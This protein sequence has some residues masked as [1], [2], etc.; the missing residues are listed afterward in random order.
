YGL[1]CGARKDAP[2]EPGPIQ[3]SLY[4]MCPARRLN[5]DPGKSDRSC[6]ERGAG[7]FATFYSNPSESDRSCLERGA[8]KDAA[9][10]PSPVQQ[11]LQRVRE[12]YGLD[13]DPGDSDRDRLNRGTG[14][15]AARYGNPGEGCRGCLER[16]ACDIAT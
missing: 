4:R 11:S 8:G 15:I 2:F 13:A 16:C 3:Q 6:F 14:E 12:G 9:L 5:G 7:R 10:E 1:E